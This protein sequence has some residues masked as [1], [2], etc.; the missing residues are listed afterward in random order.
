MMKYCELLAMM[1]L[2]VISASSLLHQDTTEQDVRV[3]RAVQGAIA[4]VCPFIICVI[5]A[6]TGFFGKC[7]LVLKLCVCVCAERRAFLQASSCAST[8]CGFRKC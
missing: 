1:S 4:I 2:V 8:A 7:V 6:A 5:V 3:Q